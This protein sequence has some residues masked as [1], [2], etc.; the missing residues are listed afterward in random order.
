MWELCTN[1]VNYTLKLEKIIVSD[2]ITNLAGGLVVVR[3]GEGLAGEAE[4]NNQLHG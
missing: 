1:E 4:D 2:E 3:A